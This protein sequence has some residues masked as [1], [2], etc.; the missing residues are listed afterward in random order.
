MRSLRITKL[1][2]NYLELR[3]QE[4]KGV[5]KVDAHDDFAYQKRKFNDLA[6]ENGSSLLSHWGG[7]GGR[8]WLWVKIKIGT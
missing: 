1:P 4:S 2:F 6:N 5:T 7:G 8:L 3:N